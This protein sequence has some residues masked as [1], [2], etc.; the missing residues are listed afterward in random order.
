[1]TFC[2]NDVNSAAWFG[3]QTK[4][5]DLGATAQTG[6][7]K[8]SPAQIRVIARETPPTRVPHPKENAR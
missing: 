1:M 2:I 3:E 7:L 5:A 4:M 6:Q 8:A